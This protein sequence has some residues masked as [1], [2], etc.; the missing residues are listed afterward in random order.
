MDETLFGETSDTGITTST[1]DTYTQ[2]EISP[3]ARCKRNKKKKRSRGDQFEVVMNKAMEDLISSQERNEARYLELE[4]KSMC[5]EKKMY[6]KVLEMQRGSCQFQMQ[7]M[8]IMSSLVNNQGRQAFPPPLATS[9]Q[10]PTS[11]Y[12][13]YND[14][15]QPYDDDATQL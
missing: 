5:M 1:N 11:S 2:R 8:Q 10:Y 12:Y 14:D 4:N 13:R 9:T 15:Y 6:D 3:P 7:M